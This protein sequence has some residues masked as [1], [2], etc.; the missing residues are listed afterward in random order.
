M[1]YKDTFNEASN[2]NVTGQPVFDGLN[3]FMHSIGMSYP[4][5]FITY[6]FIFSVCFFY[7]FKHYKNTAV[8]ALPF[9]LAATISSS[10]TFVRQFLGLGFV[11]IAIVNILNEK[12]YKF[13]FFSIIAVA[14]HNV[15]VVVILVVFALKFYNKSINIYIAIFSYLF[16]SLIF[17]MK[18]INAI[19]PLLQY[20]AFNQEHF[21]GYVENADKWFSSDA[22]NSI[23]AQ[24]I[25]AKIINILFDLSI[26][27]L[28]NKLIKIRKDDKNVSFY[29]NLFVIGSCF[30]QAFFQVE[31]MRRIG[32]SMYLFWFMVAGYVMVYFSPKVSYS[33]KIITNSERYRYM[34]TAW[35]KVLKFIILTYVTLWVLRFVFLSVDQ[36]FIWDI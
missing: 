21:Q 19:T 17:D 26:M 3:Y 2:L 5:A 14:I 7:F 35:I 25:A 13:I 36:L 24:S 12:W 15:N 8:Y 20:L 34:D 27:I 16:F 18:N 23:Y 31:L 9:F 11:F 29:Y 22:I 33:L 4:F 32:I 28:G 6:S 10:E 1:V 30:L